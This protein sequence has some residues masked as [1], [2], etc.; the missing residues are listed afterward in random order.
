MVRSRLPS[1]NIPSSEQIPA[2]TITIFSC[3]NQRWCMDREKII[4]IEAGD[5]FCI[6]PVCGYTDAFHTALKKSEDGIRY[7][8]IF[9]CPDCHS[10][11]DIGMKTR[12]PFL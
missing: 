6:C 11:F 4:R 2:G 8:I 3:V 7:D 1:E 9:I 10:R 5:E 12:E